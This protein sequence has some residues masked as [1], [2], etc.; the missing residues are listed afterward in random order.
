MNRRCKLNPCEERIK[1]TRNAS[2]LKKTSYQSCKYG[3]NGIHSS[4][5]Q[6]TFFEVTYHA[7]KRQLNCPSNS[8]LGEGLTQLL[9]SFV[10]RENEKFHD[11]KMNL[12][13][14]PRDN[15]I[16]S[17]TYY[18]YGKEAALDSIIYRLIEICQ[19]I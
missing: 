13:R 7:F 16:N 3:S 14:W 18:A 1:R 5:H 12:W 17:H 9:D 10:L 6:D 4:C 11:S 8:N 2:A 15:A 19:I